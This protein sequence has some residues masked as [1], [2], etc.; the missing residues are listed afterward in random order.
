MDITI[1][2]VCY[3]AEKTIERTFESI[4]EQ[5]YKDVEYVIVD[6]KST[7]NTVSLIKKWE[8]CFISKGIRFRWISEKDNGL[9]DAMN[10]A[11]D[12]A[13]G[14][15][16]IYM[17]ADD[18]LYSKDAIKIA[19]DNLSEDIDVLYGDAIFVS[20]NG[21]EELRKALPINTIKRHLPFIPQSAFIRT[22]LQKSYKFNLKYNIAA[23]YDFFLNIYSMGKKFKKIDYC[24]S[25]FYEG[26]VSNINEWRTYKEDID[27]KY[28]HGVI[29]NKRSP[30]QLMKYMRKWIISRG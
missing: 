3:N 12:I 7:D 18:E 1:A 19:R 30:I 2:T 27:V 26:G 6:G 15:W 13:N 9:Y 17:N 29:K 10:K 8:E 16:I 5:T 20:T 11:A 28:R 25:K 14:K 21:I 24:F 23:D 4:L 22:S